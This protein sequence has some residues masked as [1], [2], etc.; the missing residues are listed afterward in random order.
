MLANLLRAHPEAART[1]DQRR[2]V[3]AI[4]S[5][6]TA[7]RGGQLY[8]CGDCDRWHFA[9]HSCHHRACPN[10]GALPAADWRERQKLRLL[11]VPYFLQTYT[12]PAG[13][14]P[15]FKAAPQFGY[16]L[17]FAASSQ[18]LREVAL[19]KL[20][21]EPAALGVLHTWSRQLGFHPHVHYILPGGFLSPNQLRWIRLK[22][23]N[24]LL[25]ERVLSRR[26]QNLFR[27][28]LQAQRPDLFAQVPAAVWRVEWVV[29]TRPVGSGERAL[30]YLAAYVQRTALS[31]QRILKEEHGRTTF[32]YRHSDTGGWKLLTLDTGEFLRRF[33]QH[34]L[35][36]G[37][38]RVRYFGWWS[39][40]AKAKWARVLALLD[41]KAP[42]PP[43]PRP[44]WAMSCPT[45]GQPMVRLAALPRLPFK[46]P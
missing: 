2:A 31:A 41:W 26:T 30:G 28:Q 10:C 4:L 7:Q 42:P 18:A 9:Y 14:R 46:P 12:V 44:A 24:F 38:H 13:L 34:L 21:G 39:P 25:P 29:N 3:H 33:L 11:P 43:P 22:D 19:S 15:L 27:T 35:P 32:R 23:P 45:C 40:A 6:R 8:R 1:P 5:C 36:A 37:F 17:L 20:G 16:D